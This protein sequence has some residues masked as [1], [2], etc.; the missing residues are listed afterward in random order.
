[1]MPRIKINKN[2]CKGCMLC[3]TACPHGLIVKSKELNERGVH[4]VEFK[5]KGEVGPA[6]RSR[7]QKQFGKGGCTAC[8]MCA[9][10]CPDV[11][12]E[13]YK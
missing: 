6:L 5:A 10:I 13:V 2:K 4:C 11:C 9:I 8:G 1:M 3:M 7:T 12:I